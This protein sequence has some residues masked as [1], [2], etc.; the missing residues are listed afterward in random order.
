MKIK[1]TFFMLLGFCLL[2]ATSGRAQTAGTFRNPLLQNGPDPWVY[3]HRDGYYHFM[4]TSGNK[5]EIRKSKSLTGIGRATP[6]TVWTPPA[7]GPNSRDIWAPEIH[8]LD[9]KWYIYYTATDQA[10]PGDATRYVFVLEN[11]AEDPLTGTWTDKGKVNT[12]YSGL[13]GSL[14]THRGKRYFLYSAYVGPQS[15]LFI[16]EMKNPWTISERQVEIARPTFAWEKFKEREIL[17]GPQFLAGKKG[18]LHIVYSASACWDDNYAL[19]LLTAAAD[20]DL[21]AASS[22]RKAP[23][24]VFKASPENKVFGPGH[25]GFTRSPDGKEDWLVYHAKDVANGE[26]S[27][28]STRIQKFTWHADGSPDFGT[29]LSTAQPVARPAGEE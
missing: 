13:D 10:K 22:W 26:C 3:Q 4:V 21:L 28:R 29:P 19:G 25:N 15:R 17:E 1:V 12:N 8:H 2:V 6:Q 14:F 9:G 18:T 20:S 24:P 11:A 5:L 27:G 23:A 7:T 16:A